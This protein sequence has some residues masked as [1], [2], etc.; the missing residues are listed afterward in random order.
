[1][2]MTV[3]RQGHK[4]SHDLTNGRMRPRKARPQSAPVRCGLAYDVVDVSQDDWVAGDW[5]AGWNPHPFKRAA[6]R[7]SVP[8]NSRNGSEGFRQTYVDQ[9][10]KALQHVPGPGAFKTLKH[11]VEPETS[12]NFGRPNIDRQTSQRRTPRHLQKT[13]SDQ[14]K[15]LQGSGASREAPSRWEDETDGKRL[16]L[17]RPSSAPIPKKIRNASLVDLRDATPLSLPSSFYTP[18]PGAYSQYSC[19]GQ[20][21][22]GDRRDSKLRIRRQD[23][24]ALYRKSSSITIKLKRGDELTPQSSVMAR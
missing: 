2:P 21:S 5:S 17:T 14:T 16:I 23:N 7:W 13:Q 8:S 11:F 4:S 6:P 22:G 19:F 12:A 1:V 9:Q 10:L 3:C 24:S 15:K 20:P 18:G